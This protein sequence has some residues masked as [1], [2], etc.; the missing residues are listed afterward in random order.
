MVLCNI[1]T[2]RKVTRMINGESLFILSL[3]NIRVP[4][5]LDELRGMSN[6]GI[7]LKYLIMI[8]LN[9]DFIISR[10]KCFSYLNKP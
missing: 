1:S 6:C 3:F 7:R 9:W 10:L 4:L 8:I 5:N 2:R